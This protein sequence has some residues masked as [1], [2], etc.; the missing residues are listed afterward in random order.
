VELILHVDEVLFFSA[1]NKEKHKRTLYSQGGKVEKQKRNG[2]LQNQQKSANKRI[3]YCEKTDT[4][5][6]SLHVLEL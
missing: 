4:R 6:H 5:W 3:K 1:L 2:N